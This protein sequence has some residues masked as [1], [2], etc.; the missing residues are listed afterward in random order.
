M[1][2]APSAGFCVSRLY[3]SPRRA[4][5]HAPAATVNRRPATVNGSS[6]ETDSTS[7]NGPLTIRLWHLGPVPELLVASGIEE[8]AAGSNAFTI[9]RC[10]QKPIQ[11]VGDGSIA[12]LQRINFTLYLAIL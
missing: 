1:R 3:D 8:G 9:S 7:A 4:N 10:C 6:P 5:Q 2:P 11:P 12:S